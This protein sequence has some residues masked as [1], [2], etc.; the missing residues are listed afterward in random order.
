MAPGL[1][2]AAA[3]NA[4]GWAHAAGDRKVTVGTPHPAS[5]IDDPHLPLSPLVTTPLRMYFWLKKKMTTIG[6]V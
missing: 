5:A 3:R 1:S 6:S 2:Q 4:Q